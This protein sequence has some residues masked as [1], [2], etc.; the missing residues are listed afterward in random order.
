MAN[1]ERMAFEFALANDP[2]K[3]VDILRKAINLNIKDD[4]YSR[5]WYL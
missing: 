5:G 4:K 2:N 1:A 3:S